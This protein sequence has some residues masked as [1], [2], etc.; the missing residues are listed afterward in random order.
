MKKD[1]QNKE[2]LTKAR[3]LGGKNEPKKDKYYNNK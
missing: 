1:L 3:T 2:E